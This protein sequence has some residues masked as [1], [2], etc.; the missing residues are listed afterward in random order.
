MQETNVINLF[1][2]ACCNVCGKELNVYDSEANYHL[3]KNIG[4][5]SKY[6]MSEIDL[7]I[8]IDCMDKI[9]DSCAKSPIT[10]KEGC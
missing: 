10:G 6:D 2:N 8:C 4:Y 5:G 1:N 9:I 7:H 3:H